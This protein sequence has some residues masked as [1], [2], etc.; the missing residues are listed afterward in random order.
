MG[1]AYYDSKYA[2]KILKLKNRDILHEFTESA[3]KRKLKVLVHFSLLDNYLAKNIP[4][5]DKLWQMVRQ[6]NYT[7]TGFYLS[8]FAI[9]GLYG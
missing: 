9:F 8:E 2:P 1:R 4:I 5:G 6:L 3:A 7:T